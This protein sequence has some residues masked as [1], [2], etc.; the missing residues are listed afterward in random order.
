M[1]QPLISVIM[2]VYNG[3]R[4][5]YDALESI[6]AQDY[7]PLEL[8][9]VDDGSTDDSARIVQ[10]YS[11]TAAVTIHYLYQPNQGPGAA[12]SKALS[13]AQGELIAFLD[14]DD[15]WTPHKLSLQERYLRDHATTEIVTGHLHLFGEKETGWKN[16]QLNWTHYQNDPI[17][18][19]LGSLLIRRT[20][21]ARI[22]IFA[23]TYRSAD[24]VDWFLR[25]KDAGVKIAAIPEIVLL[26]RLHQSNLSQDGPQ[27]SL[28]ILQAFH[29]SI[30]RQQG[31]PR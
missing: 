16:T 13:V 26:K 21:F 9:V 4:F 5:L 3:E 23:A 25:A 20:V 11:D 30:Q 22:G 24:D 15:R 1:N 17:D 18:Y 8:I 2:A 6:F 12:R 27:V 19:S 28:E 14:Q 31:R 29:A 7:W 10:S